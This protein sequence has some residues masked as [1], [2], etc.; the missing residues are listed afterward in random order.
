MQQALRERMGS[1]RSDQTIQLDSLVRGP[2]FAIVAADLDGDG[3]I[4]LAA[5]DPETRRV[6]V[7]L[8]DG[9][10]NKRAHT[11]YK[12]GPL[13]RTLIATDID[14]DGAM[15]LVVGCLGA[16]RILDGD[17]AGSFTEGPSFEIRGS[18]TGLA[19]HVA[20]RTGRVSLI[21][22]VG[23]QTQWIDVPRFR[24]G[25]IASFVDGV[26]AASGPRRLT[27]RSTVLTAR[28]EDIVRLAVK[29]LAA[30]HIA[31]R[32]SISVRTVESHLAHVYS[33]LGISTRFELVRWFQD[34]RERA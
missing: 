2:I 12:V 29:G 10:G 30:K 20:D 6:H 33:K 11:T 34:Q 14:G 15:D 9:E 32:L 1:A 28:E 19:A 31:L 24:E 4:D 26:M 21:V 7:V 18:P 17:G 8:L 22:A 3:V 27:S 13:P 23:G 16:L 25:R 5:T